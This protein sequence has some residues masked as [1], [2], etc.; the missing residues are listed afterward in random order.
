[1]EDKQNYT[2]RKLYQKTNKMFPLRKERYPKDLSDFQMM[3]FFENAK[4]FPFLWTTNNYHQEN[5][6]CNYS[7]IF[8]IN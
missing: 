8:Q 4:F 7:L 2:S 6:A 1:M 3:F 5:L